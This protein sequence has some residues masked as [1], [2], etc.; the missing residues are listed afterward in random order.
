MKTIK[1]HHGIRRI[2]ELDSSTFLFQLRELL[3]DFRASLISRLM[4]DLSTYVDYKFHI[5]P[6]ANQLPELKIQ[7][8]SLKISRVDLGKYQDTVRHIMSQESSYLSSEPFYAEIDEH[9]HWYL[10]KYQLTLVA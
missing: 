8:Y 1:T 3:T 4:D 9:I 10:Q 6:D 2:D 7:L 5:K